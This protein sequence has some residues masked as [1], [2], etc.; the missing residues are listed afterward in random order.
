MLSVWKC[1]EGEEGVKKWPKWCY[2]INTIF[3]E[4]GFSNKLLLPAS[5]C[6]SF[7]SL[8]FLFKNNIFLKQCKNLGSYFSCEIS[9]QV[10]KYKTKGP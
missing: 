8:K 1:H 3:Y 6:Q 9:L 5:N 7:S 2:L 10:C 4:I